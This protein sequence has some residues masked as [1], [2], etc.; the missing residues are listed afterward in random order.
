MQITPADIAEFGAQH[1][2]E[3]AAVAAQRQMPSTMK[4]WTAPANTTPNRIH[5]VPGR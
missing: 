3:R 4:S 2:A 5:I 1:V